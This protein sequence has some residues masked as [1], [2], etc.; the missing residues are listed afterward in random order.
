[1]SKLKGFCFEYIPV[2]P[3]T[4]GARNAKPLDDQEHAGYSSKWYHR[5]QL[6]C[7]LKRVC[8][9]TWVRSCR[10]TR[11]GSPYSARGACLDGTGLEGRQ[12]PVNTPVPINWSIILTLPCRVFSF[13][14]PRRTQGEVRRGREVLEMVQK[15]RMVSYLANTTRPDTLNAVQEGRGIL[16][17]RRRS[18]GG[19]DH[20][21]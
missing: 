7:R 4:F 3:F 17:I 19:R 11:F 16:A 15:S 1:M 21:L 2:D 12:R 9:G 5:R 18:K 8:V 6:G 13:V 10:R 20:I 14:L